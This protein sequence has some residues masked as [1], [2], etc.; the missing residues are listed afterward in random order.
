LRAS[1]NRALL[2]AEY[3]AALEEARHVDRNSGEESPEYE[4]ERLRPNAC[5]SRGAARA[6]G[7]RSREPE[8]RH[9]AESIDPDERER[10]ARQAI[11]AVAR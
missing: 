7:G 5:G 9:R 11:G 2:V 8:M 1:E 3:D 10:A 4:L 6:R